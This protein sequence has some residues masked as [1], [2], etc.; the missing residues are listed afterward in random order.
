MTDAPVQAR[1]TMS[2]AEYARHRG[3]SR[4]AVTKAVQ[5]G[6]I[7]LEPDG[8][9]D[10]MRAD[11]AWR[12]N[13]DPSKP[14]AATAPP[15]GIG[16]EAPAGESTIAASPMSYADARALREYNLA[17]LADLEFRKQSATLVEVDEVRDVAFRTARAAR[18]LI[19]AAPDRLAPLLTGQTDQA[20]VFRMLTE[21][22][23]RVCDEL[24][25]AEAIAPDPAEPQA[26]AS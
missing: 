12:A 16:P 10:P 17:R 3:V 18:D 7:P 1:P 13:T 26:E 24:V 5:A 22:L 4:P 20:V 15:M 23:T 8:R 6:R 11:A 21:D 2:R 14:S 25:K 19:L 9:I